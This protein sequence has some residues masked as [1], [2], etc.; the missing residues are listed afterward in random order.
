MRLVDAREMRGTKSV[1]FPGE[2]EASFVTPQE[3]P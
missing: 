1:S 2:Q 3:T